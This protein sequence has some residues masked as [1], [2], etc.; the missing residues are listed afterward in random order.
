[1]KI[2]STTKKI[3]KE[4]GIA[5]LVCGFLF[6]ANFAISYTQPIVNIHESIE[7]AANVPALQTAMETLGITGTVLH[8]IPADLLHFDGSEIALSDVDE[9]HEQIITASAENPDDFQYFCAVDPEASDRVIQV[10][11]CLDEGA[12]GVKFYNGYS[13][14]HGD[15]LDD[16]SFNKLY[17]TLIAADAPLMLPLN[18]G[19]Y[20][21]ELNNLLIMYPDLKLIC[22]HY[23]LSSKSLDRL[24][25]Y[26]E[27]SENLYIDTSFG[28][29]EYARNGFQTITENHDDFTAFFTDYQDRIFF[30][31]D[32]VVTSYED[33][34]E[35]FLI[36]LYSDYISILTEVEFESAL[37]PGTTYQGLALSQSIQRKVFWH[38]WSNLLE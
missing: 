37:D 7:S 15:P 28:H 9:N 1:M 5:A 18:S 23:C 6:Q 36:N 24:R 21:D 2:S 25:G 33:K 14:T 17:D 35:D 10:E 11:Q 3:L 32:V 22:S 27:M 12:T 19:Q 20:G 8:G 30:A 34:G 38:N 4:L 26:M 13:Y 16:P 31:T 29:T